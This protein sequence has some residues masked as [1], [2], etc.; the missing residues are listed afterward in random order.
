MLKQDLV[1]KHAQ[2]A[3]LHVLIQMLFIQSILSHF[4]V[5][6]GEGVSETIP[7]ACDVGGLI[8][9]ETDLG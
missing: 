6:R 8:A 5:Q 1:N 7:P 9:I 3:I 2:L 4:W